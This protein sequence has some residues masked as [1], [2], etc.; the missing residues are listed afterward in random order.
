MNRSLSVTRATDQFKINASII[1]PMLLNDWLMYGGIMLASIL[2]VY[3]VIF[4][5]LFSVLLFS[6]NWP[7]SRAEYFTTSLSL[8]LILGV[9]G[10]L[11]ALF[12]PQTVVMWTVLT[13]LGV[14]WIGHAITWA[15]S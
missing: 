10:L 9:F 1:K 11:F 13:I 15:I 3:F 7:V 4:R 5:W 8:L 14:F 12:L 2:F 6:N